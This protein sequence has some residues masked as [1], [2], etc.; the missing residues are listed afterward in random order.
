MCQEAAGRQVLSAEMLEARYGETGLSF[1]SSG[2]R[3]DCRAPPPCPR[4]PF[5]QISENRNNLYKSAAA[6]KRKTSKSFANQEDLASLCS[7]LH[8]FSCFNCSPL[9]PKEFSKIPPLVILQMKGYIREEILQL[10]KKHSF[11]SHILGF[12][13]PKCLETLASYRSGSCIFLVTFKHG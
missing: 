5:Y 11:S 8:Q 6:S 13:F 7:C 4:S 2:K 3:C 1:F 10:E 12:V 9:F